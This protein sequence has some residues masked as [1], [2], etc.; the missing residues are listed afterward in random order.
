[1]R[2]SFG[3][4]TDLIKSNPTFHSA[5]NFNSPQADRVLSNSSPVLPVSPPSLSK[6]PS[7]SHSETW[8]TLFNGAKCTRY[9]K[10]EIILKAGDVSRKVY[11]IGVG[12]CR[13]EARTN[14]GERGQLLG[15]MKTGEIFGEITYL[16][17]GGVCVN[18]VADDEVDIYSLEREQ[19]LELFAIHPDM[20]ARFYKFLAIQIS[21]RVRKG[22]NLIAKS[23]SQ[24]LLSREISAAHFA[25]EYLHLKKE[26]LT[27]WWLDLIKSQVNSFL[28][29]L[30]FDFNAIPEN[31]I[32]QP[33][34]SIEKVEKNCNLLRQLMDRSSGDKHQMN[35]KL[36][37][38]LKTEIY[39]K[40]D[41]YIKQAKETLEE[42]DLDVNE[43]SWKDLIGRVNESY[44]DPLEENIRDRIVGLIKD[45]E[46]LEKM[47]KF[48]F[49]YYTTQKTEQGKGLSDIV[50]IT[51]LIVGRIHRLENEARTCLEVW[52]KK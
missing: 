12:L 43:S 6:T 31:Y 7:N 15:R 42:E 34:E 16:F 2:K 18:I 40:I 35:A 47:K 11:Q 27:Q 51:G 14:S 50:P 21:N 30:N 39:A 36:L 22:E 49:E 38:P 8:Q 9:A 20:A 10:D 41:Q 28:S 26:K 19:L 29:S 32:D 5:P 24:R 3:N 48:E 13:V 23:K 1:M 25:I 37:I 4:L 45:L 44:S 17:G 33:P 52:S 46:Y